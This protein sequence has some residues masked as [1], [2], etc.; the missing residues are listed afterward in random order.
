MNGIVLL[1]L[2]VI[3]GMGMGSVVYHW[4]APGIIAEMKAAR[5]SVPAGG[6]A[7]L[8]KW[9]EFGRGLIHN[10]L[11]Q[12]RM[13]AGQPWLVTHVVETSEDRSEDEIWG[14]DLAGLTPDATT[15]EGMTV[16]VALPAVRLV[17][18]GPI[19]GDKS[20]N[21]PHYGPG[22]EVPDPNAR[23][24]FVVEWSLERLTAALEKDIEGSSLKVVVGSDA[25]PGGSGG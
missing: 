4:K 15:A 13:S 21:V 8:A 25:A 14:V 17:G 16:V 2:L 19:S 9:L 12:L 24:A 10:R 22:D 23:A 20:L 18:H 1:V 3:V 11:T 5:A 7:R 6:E